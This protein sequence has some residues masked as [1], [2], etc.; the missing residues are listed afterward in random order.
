VPARKGI[1]SREQKLISEGHAATSTRQKTT[2]T[3][4]WTGSHRRNWRQTPTPLG[5]WGKNAGGFDFEAIPGDVNRAYL[6]K[7]VAV[8][9]VVS[10]AA[11]YFL[12]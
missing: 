4:C 3:A 9:S 6:K 2:T 10:A 12:R 8:D 1:T 11:T 7:Y 5:L